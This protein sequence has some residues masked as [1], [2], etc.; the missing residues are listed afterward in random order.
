MYDKREMSEEEIK[1]H[2]ITPAL[3]KK[4]DKGQVRMEFPLT[5]GKINMKGN[6][7]VRE[8]PK[9]ADYVLTLDGYNALAVVEAKS[10]KYAVSY[11]LQQAKEYAKMLDIS[12]AYSSNGD[13]FEEYD[14][15]T[16]KEREIPLEAFPS[17]QDLLQRLK[18][19]GQL[20]PAKE[21]VLTKPFYT[22]QNTYPPR[23]YQQIAV[24]RVLK[25]VA[26]GQKRLLLV[27]ATGTG[28]TYTAFQI[29][30]RLKQSAKV[31]KVLYLADR[32]I[33]VDQSITQD[34]SPLQKVIHKVNFARDDK[35]TITS[36]EIYFA[37]YQQLVGNDDAPH[38]Q[39]LF[40]PE[41]FDLIIVDE[42]HRGSAKEESRWRK[43]LDYFKTAIQLG[44]T[45]TPK[46]T[47]Y[48]SNIDYFGKPVYTYSLKQGIDDGFL[49]PFRVINVHMNIGDGWRPKKGQ[50]DYYGH[51]I[52]DRVYNNADY[53]YPGGVVLL[54]RIREVAQRIT[55]YLK[56]TD[57]Y[58]KTIVFC[59][60]EAAAERMRKE[61]A[62]LNPERMQENPDYVVR[63]TGSDTYGKGKLSYFISVN[64]KYPVIA[65][66]SELLSTGVDCKMVKLIVLD[67]N[68]QS[69]TAFKQIVGRGTRLRTDMGKTHFTIMDFRG[70][71]RLF[72]DPDWD[73]PIIQ[74]PDFDPKQPSQAAKDKPA[75]RPPS[76]PGDKPS[77]YYVTPDGCKVYT[78]NE[79][80]SVYDANGKLLRQENIIDYTRKNILGDYG[81]LKQFIRTWNQEK[82]K[83]AIA[84]ALAQKG[85]DLEAL[86]QKLNLA[87]IDDFDFICHLAY[88]QKPLTRRERAEAVKK[89]DGLQQYSGKAREVLDLLLEQYMNLGLQNLENTKI[90]KMKDFWPY[91]KP[92]VIAKLFGGKAGYQ[93]AV[94]ALENELYKV[95]MR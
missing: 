46:E 8:R 27:M 28:K 75:V 95:G 80:Y 76:T 39:E 53:D 18:K 66:T 91:G 25:A 34:F 60:D 19:D 12:F 88:D 44:M 69:M 33:L 45:A 74:E 50:K 63:I 6:L 62:Q 86:K 1:L 10:H 48:I 21:N 58:A 94:A 68:I 22:S 70:V 90:L 54:D 20:T 47:K 13:A 59:A 29:V 84:Q 7:Y 23:Y 37:L 2:Y 64:A 77:K 4:W 61:L 67:K 41:F 93:Q 52:P 57:P 79:V 24:D 72:A 43:V 87:D 26:A 89:R 32:N 40:D 38:F 14:F 83:T 9:K 55:A 11:G 16:G 82:K 78:L 81:D 3:L 92:S 17:A 42:C 56:R 73:G 5:A 15:L 30:W 85:I 65:T 51:E 71:T 36:Y 35:T 49:A 31:R